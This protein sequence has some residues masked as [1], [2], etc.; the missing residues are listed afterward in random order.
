MKTLLFV[1]ALALSFAS[2]FVMQSTAGGAH[3]AQDWTGAYVPARLQSDNMIPGSFVATSWAEA[4][5][6]QKPL[7]S[8]RCYLYIQSS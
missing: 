1:I 4:Y 2:V 8:D 6:V 5:A 3:V 7:N